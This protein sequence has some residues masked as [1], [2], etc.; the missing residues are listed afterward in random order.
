MHC[1]QKT[2]L[3]GDATG[4]SG[5]SRQMQHSRPSADPPPPAALLA[6]E[7]AAR[8]ASRSRAAAAKSRSCSERSGSLHVHARAGR[9]ADVHMLSAGQVYIKHVRQALYILCRYIS[10]EFKA[11]R[12]Q[13]TSHGLHERV[14][15]YVD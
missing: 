1:L 12:S 15:C 13:S 9:Q 11:A 7:A 5:A 6:T 3:Q 4:S 2:W 14:L 8:F 10:T